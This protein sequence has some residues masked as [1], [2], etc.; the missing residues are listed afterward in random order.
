MTLTAP[1]VQSIRVPEKKIVAFNQ[2]ALMPL[3]LFSNLARRRTLRSAV[4]IALVVFLT[5]GAP[6]LD[7]AVYYVDDDTGSDGDDGLSAA[8]AFETITHALSVASGGD[9]INVLAGTY[10]DA[11]GETFP[12]ALKSGV[13]LLGA[14]SGSVTSITVDDGGSGFDSVPDVTFTGGGGI[15]AEAFAVVESGAVTEVIVTGGGGGYASAPTVVFPGGTPEAAAAATA[16]VG[17]GVSTI[18]GLEGGPIFFNDDALSD[19]TRLSGFLLKYDSSTAD[20]FMMEFEVN[21][22]AM[23]P[24]I[25]HN[26]F[27]DYEAAGSGDYGILY[28]DN[29]GGDGSFTGLIENNTMSGLWIGFWMSSAGTTAGGTGDNFSPTIQNNSFSSVDW[30]IGF[31]FTAS[32]G[33]DVAPTVT[34]NTTWGGTND[35][36]LE[37]TMGS[38]FDTFS[39]TVTDNV[40]RESTDASVN[41]TAR[42]DLGTHSFTPTLTGNTITSPGNSGMS[43]FLSPQNS[44]SSDQVLSPVIRGNTITDAG[45]AGIYI[46]VSDMEAG[47]TITFSPTIESNTVTGAA[48]SGISIS[49]SGFEQGDLESNLTISGNTVTDAGSTG[50]NVELSELSDNA[51]GGFEADWMI[52]NNTVTG[53]AFDGITVSISSLDDLVGSATIRF[54]GNVVSG[55]GVNG[56]SFDFDPDSDDVPGAFFFEGNVL[57]D[58]DDDGLDFEIDRASTGAQTVL[59][60]GNT[61]SGNG[62]DGIDLSLDS[63]TNLTSADMRI[64]GNAITDNGA[65]GIE[66]FLIEDIPSPI[67][68][69]CNTIT[70]NDGAG[71]WIGDTSTVRTESGGNAFT[72]GED[73]NADSPGHNKIF[74]NTTFDVDNT[75]N[76]TLMAENNWWGVSPPDSGQFNGDVDYDPWLTTDSVTNAIIADIEGALVDDADSSGGATIGDIIRFCTTITGG[77]NCGSGRAVTLTIPIPANTELVPG[78]ITTTH[79]AIDPNATGEV[80]VTGIVLEPGEE[81]TVCFDVEAISEGE[82]TGDATADGP[83]VDPSEDSDTFVIGAP[84][85]GALPA[86]IPTAGEWGLIG[87]AILLALAGLL[88]IRRGGLLALILAAALATV[89]APGASA[90]PMEPERRAGTIESVAVENGKVTLRMADGASWTLAA[91]RLDV[92]DRRMSREERRQARH[93]ARGAKGPSPAGARPARLD[94]GHLAAI[95]S[96]PRVASGPARSGLPAVVTVKLDR[97]EGTV[98]KVQVKLYASQEA[99]ERAVRE[100]ERPDRVK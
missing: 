74:D 40:F 12:L 38:E 29:S 15:G 23:A 95:L 77:G 58:N 47:G 98:R 13:A 30:P 64:E 9:T 73:G 59:I 88:I 79:G 8:E 3:A 55:S 41:M 33:G 10:D 87:M 51:S 19:T 84:A 7:A 70:G 96:A 89:A 26:A 97:R 57:T 43:L 69:S 53:S 99:A 61:M 11:N 28:Y 86:D 100:R 75:T 24:R 32:Q 82:A 37:G 94:A 49:M 56:I 62:D 27:V 2:E 83:D 72:L 60:R 18:S 35:F 25:D 78:S 5:A 76:P 6:W 1:A 39:P 44:E 50:I 17:S 90:S 22:V 80:V 52:A 93:A 14:G 92:E 46:E 85:A 16:T 42:M 36:L 34:N 91:G 48:N 4:G 20:D 45:T 31:S 66:A 21:S 68:V 81:A 54:V 63:Q 65:N 71:L 67:V